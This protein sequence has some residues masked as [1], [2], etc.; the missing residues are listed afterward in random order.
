MN[1]IINTGYNMEK[2][3]CGL[4]IKNCESGLSTVK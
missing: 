1:H 2:P 3:T 4:N